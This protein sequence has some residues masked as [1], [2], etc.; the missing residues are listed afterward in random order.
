MGSYQFLLIPPVFFSKTVTKYTGPVFWFRLHW[1]QKRH[2]ATPPPARV[3]RRMKRNRQK[4]VGQDK[5]SL[6]EQQTEGTVTPRIQIRRKYDTDSQNRPSLPDR[7]GATRSPAASEF[8][9]RRPPPE[10]SMTAHGMEYLALFGQVG[11]G[12]A[13]PAVPLPGFR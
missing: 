2:A 4:S 3:R 7:T 10:P 13:H 8:L 12:S 6:T 1:Q 5:G 9:L 11:V